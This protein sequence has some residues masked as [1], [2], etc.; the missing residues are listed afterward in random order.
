MQY[1][2]EEIPS[3][4]RNPS[5]KYTTNT[6]SVFVTSNHIDYPEQ[7]VVTCREAGIVTKCLYTSFDK[8]NPLASVEAAKNEA[9]KRVR[10]KLDF[11]LSQLPK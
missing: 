7:W 2:W 8:E 4:L 10:N 11:M 9:I 5:Y 6:F 1:E 3:K